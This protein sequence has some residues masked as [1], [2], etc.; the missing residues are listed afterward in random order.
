MESQSPTTQERLKLRL[1]QELATIG[2][3]RL[4]GWE[5]FFAS[6]PKI[7]AWMDD[8]HQRIDNAM[9]DED[10]VRFEKEMASITKAW[11]R[12]NEL[13]AEDYRKKNEDP[14]T[15]ELRFIKWM[16]IAFIKF[17]SPLGEFYLVPRQPKRRPKAAHWYTVDEMLTFLRPPIAEL[18]KMSGKLPGRPEDLKP[19]GP[20]EQVIHIDATGPTV[21]TTYE[22]YKKP[23]Y[24]RT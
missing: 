7:K 6:D 5:A 21:K 17:D 9:R 18:I 24:E 11:G 22:L 10:D 23:R 1:Q 3:G 19:P 16:K 2:E 8:L 4:P 13:V 15:W 14:S 20:G 12:V